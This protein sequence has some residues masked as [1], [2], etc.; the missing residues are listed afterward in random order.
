VKKELAR[1][2][3]PK[4]EVNDKIGLKDLPSELFDMILSSFLLDDWI[5][6]RLANSGLIP[7]PETSLNYL[8]Q[9]SDLRNL[10]VANVTRG[11]HLLFESIH[12]GEDHSSDAGVDP[13]R[14]L[15]I[16]FS[17]PPTSSEFVV[18]GHTALS[19]SLYRKGEHTWREYFCDV[20]WDIMD[21]PCNPVFCDGEFYCLGKDGMLALFNPEETDEEHQSYVLPLPK[22]SSSTYSDLPRSFHNFIVEYDAEIVSVFVGFLGYPICM[23]KLDRSKMKW[24]TSNNLDDKMLFLSHTSSTLLPAKLKGTE[25]RIYFPRFHGN[26]SVFYSLS[27]KSYRCFGSN[28]WRQD[29]MNSCEHLHCTWIQS[30]SAERNKEKKRCIR[31]SAHEAHNYFFFFLFR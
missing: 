19:L 20:P 16:S 21:Y 7:I 13:C 29:W 12:Y 17:A 2:E 28:H 30:G 8:V 5:R 31:L 15:G 22:V 23:F 4:D 26:E 6:F 25:N 3:E 14:F 27:T 1:V 11:F 9:S 24:S 18:F 10:G